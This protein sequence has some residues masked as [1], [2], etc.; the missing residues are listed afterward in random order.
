MI[1]LKIFAWRLSSIALKQLKTKQGCLEKTRNKWTKWIIGVNTLLSPSPNETQINKDSLALWITYQSEF[2]ED[3]MLPQ[4]VIN[5]ILQHRIILSRTVALPNN[6]RLS[7]TW[8]TRNRTT[9]TVV[10]NARNLCHLPDCTPLLHNL[11]PVSTTASPTQKSILMY[12][13]IMFWAL[14]FVKVKTE[15]LA[16]VNTDSL[17][18]SPFLSVIYLLT[19]WE[20]SSSYCFFYYIRAFWI[21]DF[22]HSNKNKWITIF[23]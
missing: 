17:C 14:D 1:N 22:I 16:F 8:S 3:W 15:Q 9:A 6:G 13:V 2:G 4:R 11:V 18:V 20:R 21:M 7:Q 23:L 10:T 12:V 19:L 5:H